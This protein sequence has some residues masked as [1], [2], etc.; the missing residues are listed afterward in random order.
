MIPLIIG[1]TVNYGA[2]L[3]N[4]VDIHAEL[5]KHTKDKYVIN[6]LLCI[7]WKEGG[8][9]EYVYSSDNRNSVFLIPQRTAS[10]VCHKTAP[11]IRYNFPV[12]AKC[13]VQIHEKYGT[14]R[15]PW[16]DMYQGQ[17]RRY[18]DTLKLKGNAEK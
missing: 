9:H 11:N 1:V 14:S 17:C 6:N 16:F 10:L 13:A 5:S 3:L 4:P 2:L 18:I 15:W 7:A 8:N 12:A